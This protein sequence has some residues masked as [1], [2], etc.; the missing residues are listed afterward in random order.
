MPEATVRTVVQL[1]HSPTR[2]DRLDLQQR[3]GLALTDYLGEL[4]Y[5]E[6]VAESQLVGLGR[7]PLVHSTR[8][9]AEARRPVGATPQAFRS[10][11]A[12]SRTGGRLIEAVLFHDTDVAALVNNQATQVTVLDD[13]S[14]GGALKVRLMADDDHIAAL[15][16]SPDVRSLE[17]VGE[18]QLDAVAAVAHDALARD[19]VAP[20]WSTGLHG[21][22]QTIGIIDSPID[23][24]HDYFRDAAHPIGPE[25]RKVVGFRNGAAEPPALHGTFVAGIAAG[26][27][28]SAPGAD[29][30]RGVAW[31]ARLSYTNADDV[32][33]TGALSALAAAAADGARVHTNS[34]HDEPEPQY[35]QLAADLDAFTWHNEDHVLVGSAGNTGEAMG[36][37]G[38]AK[39]TLSVSASCGVTPDRFGDGAS[40][41]AADGRHKP[42]LAAP[43][44][45]IRSA[46]AGTADGVDIDQTVFGSE[47]PIC[48]SSWAAPAIAGLCALTRQ[49]FVEGRY[50]SGTPRAVD[51]LIP[52][53]AL[54]RATLLAGCRQEAADEPVQAYPSATL[55]WG[56]VRLENTLRPAGL[57]V[58]DVRHEHG[59]ATGEATSRTVNVTGSDEALSVT[60]AWTDPPGAAGSSDPRVNRLELSVVPPDGHVSLPGNAFA[61]GFSGPDAASGSDDNVQRVLVQHPAVG[62]WTV[63]ITGTAVNV[64][65]PGQGYAVVVTGALEPSA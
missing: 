28:E 17:E 22:G 39:N 5:V 36:P 34:W 51:T 61:G 55:G 7:D 64:A 62:R 13:R 20:L 26:D 32:E 31:A 30:G 65:S 14:S 40:G 50:P 42:D 49:Y 27:A 11:T 18:V 48:A 19:W 57:R 35:N 63:L 33:Q 56:V 24:A 53:G 52:S 25:H 2:A 45:S 10:A 38:T 41:P 21:E 4:S 37:P 47:L 29:P 43:G 15:S 6:T 12:H 59:L 16:A 54:L 46:V 9:F 8:N 3:Y 44:C 23:V 58:W 60:L 1:Q